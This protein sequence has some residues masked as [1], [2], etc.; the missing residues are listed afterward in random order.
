M[1]TIGFIPHSMNTRVI[2]ALAHSFTHRDNPHGNRNSNIAFQHDLDERLEADGEYQANPSLPRLCYLVSELIHHW[3]KLEMQSRRMS[4]S[5]SSQSSTDKRKLSKSDKCRD[6]IKDPP[7]SRCQGCNRDNHRR[8]DCR[9]RTHPDFNELGQWDGCLADHALRRWQKDEKEIKLTC[10]GEREL[11]APYYLGWLQM[12]LYQ[13]P[14]FAR[15]MRM[16]EINDVDGIMNVGIVM[17][18][19]GITEVVVVVVI[20]EW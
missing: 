6:Q 12:Q 15:M 8:E 2:T 13:L 5:T 3:E 16:I 18:I 9:F 10:V 7:T 17:V 19:E 11:M 4:G 20:A 14:L 1:T